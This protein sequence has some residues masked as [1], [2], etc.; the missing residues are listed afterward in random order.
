MSICQRF[1]LRTGD[2]C[3]NLITR[4]NLFY[5]FSITHTRDHNEV[6]IVLSVFLKV[7]F[8]EGGLICNT[9]LI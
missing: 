3:L 5:T 2:L 9:L 7:N 8:L 4:A 1:S 6:A